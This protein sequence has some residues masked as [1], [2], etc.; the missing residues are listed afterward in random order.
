MI[1]PQLELHKISNTFENMT[2]KHDN[3]YQLTIPMQGTCFFTHEHKPVTLSAGEGLILQ[4]RDSHSF[5]IEN[6]ASVL[7]IRIKTLDSNNQ[8]H[9]MP[10]EFRLRQ[11]FDIGKVADYYQQW[12]SELLVPDRLDPMAVDETES[13]IL[14]GVEELLWGDSSRKTCRENQPGPDFHYS[15]VLEYIHAHYAEPINVDTLAS[16]AMQSR[17]HFIRSFKSITGL[18]PYQYVLQRRVEEAKVQLKRTGKT[19][20]EISFELGFA[21]T[22]QFHRAFLKNVGMTPERYRNEMRI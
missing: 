8:S 19:V 17:Y 5:H 2:H 9:R 1:L 13:R 15:R 14:A 11:T 7:I 22:S 20:T 4:P 10:E 18:S 3:Q 6:G 12:A 16:M 21:S